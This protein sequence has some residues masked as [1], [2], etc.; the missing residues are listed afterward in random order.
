M[1]FLG[2][3]EVDDDLLRRAHAVHPITA[4]PERVLA[5]DPR[6]G[7]GRAAGHARAGRRAGPVLA[8]RPWLPHRHARPLRASARGTSA[9]GNPRFVGEAGEANEKI[10]AA[11]RAVAE[12]KGVAAAQVA[13]AWVHGRRR[14]RRPGRAHP[15]HQAAQWLEQNAAALD[16]VLDDQDDLAELDPLGRAGRRRPVLTRGGP[17]AALLRPPAVQSR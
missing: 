11:V 5:L 16:V 14:A 3:S 4:R 12:R 1:R 17:R 8:A 9:R 7:D 2:L 6:P 10:A 13:L 15:G